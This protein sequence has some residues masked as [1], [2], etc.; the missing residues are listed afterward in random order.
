VLGEDLPQKLKYKDV[1]FVMEDVD[2]KKKMGKGLY[3]YY[4]FYYYYFYYYYCYY[5]YPYRCSYYHLLLL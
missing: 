3:Y 1:I 5:Y 2:G 4:Y